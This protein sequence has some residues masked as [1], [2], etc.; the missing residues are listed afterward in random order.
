MAASDDNSEVIVVIALCVAGA[1]WYALWKF[2]T[3]LIIDI[4]TG[5]E[6][7]KSFGL[8]SVLAWIAVRFRFI[9]SKYLLPVVLAVIG[10]SLF[11][12]LDYWSSHQVV[13]NGWG[14]AQDLAWYATWWGK[15][16]VAFAPGSLAAIF[17]A[18]F[19]GSDD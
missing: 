5:I 6:V 10:L 2:S 16:I 8:F 3:A 11:P 19:F 9:A 18:W 13:V 14:T 12:A 7:I 1:I 17:I 4:P 15:M